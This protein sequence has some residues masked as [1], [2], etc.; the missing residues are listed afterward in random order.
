MNVGG[1]R[2]YSRQRMIL[3]GICL[4]CVA[5]LKPVQDKFEMRRGEP[6]PDPDLLYFS[7]PTAV[8]RIALGF[9]GLLADFYWMRS[10]QYYG[11][12]EEADKRTVRFKN[13]Y[14]LLDITTTLD[15]NLKDSYRTGSMFL[16]EPEPIGAGQPRQALKLLDKGIAVHPQEWQ[17]RYDKGFVYYL[18][19]QD[20]KSAGETWMEA[21]KLSTTPHWMAGLAAMSLSKGDAVDVAI[22]LWQRQYRESDR[23][24]VRENARNHLLSFQVAS[25]L[26]TLEALIAKYRAK[27]GSFPRSL[28]ELNRGRTRPYATVDPLGTPYDYDPE[29][30]NVWLS[31][32]TKI[33]YI[34]VPQTYR[35]QLRIT[36]DE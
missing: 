24:D 31:L 6:E 22:A 34:Q 18:Y 5:L 14:T 25:D 28:L 33:K 3:Y 36:I 20:Y 4:L 19:L 11:R 13:L 15:P 12:R 21:S 30:G 17:L 26:A 10:I 1:S 29:T 27:T 2:L 7:S 16:S 9:D 8:K 32:D 23:A 35:E